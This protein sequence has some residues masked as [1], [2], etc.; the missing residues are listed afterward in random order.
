MAAASP[1]RAVPTSA[2]P[3]PFAICD[4]HF[5]VWDTRAAPNPNL[6]A[7]G[8]ALPVYAIAD[9]VAEATAGGLTLD[10][11]VHVE[12]MVGQVDGGFK[13]DA[14]AETGRVSADFASPSWWGGRPAAIVPFVHLGR[15]DAAAVLDAHVA[16]SASVSGAPR[17]VGIRMILSWDDEV[18]A[19]C[20]P[21]VGTGEYLRGEHATFARK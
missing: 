2:A 9:Y 10:S 16:A 7:C 17:V 13:L 4:P 14:V 11:A 19:L 3:P 21:Q 20:W 12:T 5:H 1:L 18:P 8:T 6:G 15:D